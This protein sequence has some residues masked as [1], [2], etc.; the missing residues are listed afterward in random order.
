MKAR[1]YSLIELAVVLALLAVAFATVLP[2]AQSGRAQHETEL[3]LARTVEAIYGEHGFLADLGRLPALPELSERGALP[4]ARWAAGVPVGW[5]G[6]YLEGGAT[7]AWSHPLRLDPDGRVRSAGANG[8]FGD[9][10]DLIAPQYPPLP[11]GAAGSLCIEAP[12]DAQV[13]ALVPDESGAPVWALAAPASGCRH[14]FASLPA[15]RRLVQAGS[16]SAAVVVSRGASAVA[17]LG[18][19]L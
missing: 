17:R 2:L 16:D 1:G 18:G 6:P 8:I 14:F 3:A 10:D 9:E 7:D 15:G 13:Q 11:R 4:P 5:A 19:S 12:A